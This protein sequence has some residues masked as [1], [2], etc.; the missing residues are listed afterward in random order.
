[1]LEA[2]SNAPPNDNSVKAVV[3]DDKLNK[4]WTLEYDLDLPEEL[5]SYIAHIPEPKEKKKNFESRNLWTIM[6][7]FS[8]L[9]RMHAMKI[10]RQHTNSGV[11]NF[12]NKDPLADLLEDLLLETNNMALM[13]EKENEKQTRRSS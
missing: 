2:D 8:Y 4:L 5:S 11:E 12:A 3:A 9:K 6:E 10:S 13:E 1:M 7:R